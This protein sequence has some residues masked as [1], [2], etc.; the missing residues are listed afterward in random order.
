MLKAENAELRTGVESKDAALQQLQD[1]LR[2]HACCTSWGLYVTCTVQVMDDGVE[3][4]NSDL[5]QKDSVMLGL[6]GTLAEQEAASEAAETS[7]TQLNSAVQKLKAENTQ[8]RQASQ[9]TNGELDGLR[10]QH[11]VLGVSTAWN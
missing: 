7:I 6:A 1:K 5:V 11:K 3:A 2:V 10:Q 4:M 8:L 9:S